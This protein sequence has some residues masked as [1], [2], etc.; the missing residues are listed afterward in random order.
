MRIPKGIKPQIV[1]PTIT[2]SLSEGSFRLQINENHEK[3][4]YNENPKRNKAKYYSVKTKDE[5]EYH[6][7][8]KGNKT[9]KYS[10][11]T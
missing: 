6:E 4:K 10:L 11:A 2:R 3:K 8:S 9:E 1:Q 5:I 7:N